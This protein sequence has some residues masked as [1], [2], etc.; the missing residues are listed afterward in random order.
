MASM[1]YVQ[2][3][4]FS[5]IVQLVEKAGLSL[6]EFAGNPMDSQRQ[7]DT[8]AHILMNQVIIKIVSFRLIRNMRN[9]I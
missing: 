9:E 3:N 8:H 1:R 4:I 5:K 7:G 2:V 6:V